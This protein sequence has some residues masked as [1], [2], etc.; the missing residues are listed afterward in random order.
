MTDFAPRDPDQLAS[1]L[2]DGLVPPD[3]AARLRADPE[4]AARVAGIE[5]VRAAVRDV[6]PPPVGALDRMVAAALDAGVDGAVDGAPPVLPPGL[7]AVPPP[8]LSAPP[9][10]V[11]P[12]TPR[13]RA[14]GPWLAAAAAIVVGALA[15]GG[16]L[17]LGGSDSDDMATSDSGNSEESSDQDA[18]GA[19]FAED[20]ASGDDGAGGADEGDSG[21][22]TDQG[23]EATAGPDAAEESDEPPMSALSAPFLG[24]FPSAGEL[25][26]R[27]V[28][29][30]QST[31]PSP[32]P[33]TGP[34]GAASVGCPGLRPEG[35]PERGPAS[36]YATAELAGAPVVVHVYD[37]DSSEERLVATDEGCVDVIDVAYPTG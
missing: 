1:D 29:S 24:S 37:G 36:F 6:P 9:R 11:A 35:D 27:V 21:S 15:I 34:L 8:P 23:G 17:S 13:S 20:E 4:V 2:V 32:V 25:V 3:E 12:P 33:P 28:D 26:D 31:E 5:A 19:P 10:H 7:H 18:A 22:A 30:R 16:V 14:A